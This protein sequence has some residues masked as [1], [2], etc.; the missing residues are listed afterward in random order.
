MRWT[1]AYALAF[2]QAHIFDD[3]EAAAWLDAD[4]GEEIFET[5]R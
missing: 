4:R 5:D 1:R 3:G 2:A